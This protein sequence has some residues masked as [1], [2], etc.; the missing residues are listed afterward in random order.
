MNVNSSGLCGVP[1]EATV[2]VFIYVVL[3]GN[4]EFMVCKGLLSAAHKHTYT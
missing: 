4:K 3:N 2:Q 1:Q